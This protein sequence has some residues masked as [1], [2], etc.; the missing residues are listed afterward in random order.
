MASFK[1]KQQKAVFVD[2]SAKVPREFRT[3][4]VALS[5]ALIA[6]DAP[7]RGRWELRRLG[8]VMTSERAPLG[9][10]CPGHLPAAP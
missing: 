7:E 2:Q 4:P 1:G 9:I 3:A 5:G 6:G 10:A 8:G